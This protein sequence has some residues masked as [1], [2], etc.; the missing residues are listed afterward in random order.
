M[1]LIRDAELYSLVLSGLLPGTV[2]TVTAGQG[3]HNASS[4]FSSECSLF[5]SNLYVNCAIVYL[6]ETPGAISLPVYTI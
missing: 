6:N 4:S 2:S 5:F 1:V 3:L